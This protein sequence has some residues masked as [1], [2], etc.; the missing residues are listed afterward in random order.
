ME[1]GKESKRYS[2]VF[3]FFPIVF[4]SC[5]KLPPHFGSKISLE[6]LETRDTLVHEPL[7]S[8]TPEILVP[9]A[10]FPSPS[11]PWPYFVVFT[12][13]THCSMPR[14]LSVSLH[15]VLTGRVQSLVWPWEVTHVVA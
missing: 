10:A 4:I 14:K 8:P 9:N 7:E 5:L 1:R 3:F 15:Q 12:D 13:E 2:V 11:G 6:F